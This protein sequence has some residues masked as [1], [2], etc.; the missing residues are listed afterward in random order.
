M[1]ILLEYSAVFNILPPNPIVFNLK[2]VDKLIFRWNLA[3]SFH[4]SCLNCTQGLF[5]TEKQYQLCTKM[6][7][8]DRRASV[9]RLLR[10]VL[11]PNRDGLVL[12]ALVKEFKFI[13]GG[14]PLAVRINSTLARI[15]RLKTIVMAT[16]TKGFIL[17]RLWKRVVKRNVFF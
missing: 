11:L 15:L 8:S 2:V 13:T 10:S 1:S 17:C 9:E 4:S 12:E 7:K 16:K 6:F 3:V 5:Y 14:Q